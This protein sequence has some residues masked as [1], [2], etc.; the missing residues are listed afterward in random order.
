MPSTIKFGKD[1]RLK[2][3]DMAPTTPAFSQ[4]GGEGTLSHDSSSDKI[5]TSSKDDGQVKSVAMGQSQQ[6]ISISGVCNTPDVGLTNLDT[7][8]KAGTAVN[9][10]L[11][12]GST[13]V[14]VASCFV[15]DRKVS[16]DNNQAVK[17][18]FTLSLNGAPTTDSLFT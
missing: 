14:Y 1:T 8:F 15:G 11:T 18:S 6:S 16:Y 3:S 7:A 17:W 10:K 2:V 9:I 13:D 4:V 12:R 5:D